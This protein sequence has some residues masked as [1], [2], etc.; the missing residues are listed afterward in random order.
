M[1]SDFKKRKSRWDRFNKLFELS[2]AEREKSFH[3]ENL[4]FLKTFVAMEMNNYNLPEIDNAQDFSEVIEVLRLNYRQWNQRL[5]SLMKATSE[6]RD[7]QSERNLLH[8]TE[9]CPWNMLLEV[10]RD[11]PDWPR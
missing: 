6:L 3:Q 11:T 10:V 4:A 7:A 1:K 9:T 8:F 5:M 2:K